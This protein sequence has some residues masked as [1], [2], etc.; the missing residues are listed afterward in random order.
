MYLNVNEISQRYGISTST[1]WRWVAAG[2]FPKPYK[3][4]PAASRWHID[5]LQRFEAQKERR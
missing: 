1:I 3:I 5:E 2:I 4:G